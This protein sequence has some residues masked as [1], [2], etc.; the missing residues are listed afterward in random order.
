VTEEKVVTNE[1]EEV[2][3]FNCEWPEDRFQ[4][5]VEGEIIEAKVILVRDDAAFVDIGGKSDLTIPLEELTHEQVISAKEVVKVGDVLKVMVTKNSRDDEKIL[6]SKRRVDQEQVWIVLEEAQTKGIPVIGK[7]TEAIKGGLSVTLNGIRAFMPASQAALNFMNDLT[8][9]EG[10]EF[11]VKII[12]FDRAKRR[13]VVSRKELL[14]A[15]REKAEIAFYSKIQENEKCQGKVTR[16]TDF[17]AFVDLG[18]GIEGLIHVSELSWNRV[19]NASELLKV[20][21]IV[22]VL[23]TKVD[24]A[25]KRISLSMKQLQAH[26]WHETAAK[27]QEGQV[28]TGTVA[29]LESFGAFIRLAPGV[30][31]LAHVSQLSEKRISKPDEVLQLGQEIQVKIIKLDTEN[32]K[33][34]LSMK[35][36]ALEH[37]QAE[38]GDYLKTQDES[39]IAQ[40]LGDLFKK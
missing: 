37:E 15:E 2:E 5:L 38:L 27:F 35:E 19:K 33:I 10:E 34:S 39:S 12:E 40:N 20:G 17:G 30:D 7:V 11:P 25:A 6:L 14:Q 13:V 23:V 21:D 9:L 32:R 18:S 26:P 1:S 3:S 24:S 36:V 28:V 31:G 16:L 4:Q 22:E 8:I 29:K